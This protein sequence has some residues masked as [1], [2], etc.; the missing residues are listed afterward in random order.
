MYRQY[1]FQFNFGNVNGVLV[2]ITHLLLYHVILMHDEIKMSVWMNGCGQ[3]DC[4][5]F[6][7]I[8]EFILHTSQYYRVQLSTGS[9]SR[10]GCDVGFKFSLCVLSSRRCA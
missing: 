6:C 2:F 5:P 8:Y 3:I 10:R 9:F 7:Y 4:I 1:V